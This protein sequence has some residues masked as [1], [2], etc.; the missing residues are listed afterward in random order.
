ML[1]ESETILR[2]SWFPLLV[3]SIIEYLANRAQLAAMRSAMGDAG[4]QSIAGLS[5]IWLWQ[6]PVAVVTV[7]AI[8]MAAVA[9]YRVILFD[10]R[11]PGRHINL[12]FGPTERRFTLLLTAMLLPGAL[13]AVVSLGLVDA[14]EP[15][16]GIGITSTA[17]IVSLVLFL[18]L[19]V[20]MIRLGPVFAIAVVDNRYDFRQAWSL[21]RGNFWRLAAVLIVVA[22]PVVV[23][24]NVVAI[25]IGPESA[26]LLQAIMGFIWSIVYAALGVAI[27]SYSY[28]ALRGRQPDEIL[29]PEESAEVSRREL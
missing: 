21:T 22:V 1:R 19:L 11:Q 7:I 6:I 16:T 27:A 24:T 28:K 3:L 9:L 15:G 23:M 17:L 13:W 18:T 2:L 12:A 4:A 8:S 20:M 29:V 14:M 25:L 5:A 10:E 26:L